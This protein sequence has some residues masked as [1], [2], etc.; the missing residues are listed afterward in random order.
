M[1]LIQDLRFALRL[2]VKERW[3]SAV[4]VLALT[5]G[6]GVNAT[7]FT[8]VNAVLV[9][10]LPF[11]DSQNLYMMG[12]RRA[13]SPQ[14]QSLSHPDLQE[15]RAQSRTFES[16]AGFTRG[17][18]NLADDTSFPVQARG[19]WLTAN[20]F[21]TLGQQPL[22]GRDFAPDD[23][24]VGAEHVVILGYSLWQNR[25]GGQAS[26]LGRP[27]RING[28]PATIIGVM[29][30]GMMFPTDSELWMAFVPNKDQL[31]RKARPLQIFGRLRSNSTRA[32]GQAEL[33]AI[34][35]M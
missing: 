16:I 17:S 26:V 24:R 8:L 13:P 28:E 3:F 11:K 2:I 1:S 27:L 18:M 5:L 35:A 32:Q 12:P 30:E 14:A 33:D 20:A 6:I 23:D 9:R 22:L 10:G 19:T 15:W 25:Y 4:A 29:P 21:R 31:T 7:V 34:A